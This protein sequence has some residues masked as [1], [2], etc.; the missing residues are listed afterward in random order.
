M[1]RPI[2]TFAYEHPS[3]MPLAL[4]FLVS[5]TALIAL[6]AKHARQRIPKTQENM[7]DTPKTPRH[8]IAA[9]SN[10]TSFSSNKKCSNN[11]SEEVEEQD[12]AMEGFGEG[13]IWQK[14]ILMGEKCQPPVFSGAIYYDRHGNQL[15]ELLRSPRASP[16]PS[17]LAHIEKE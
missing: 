4:A 15:P 3:S 14:S 13:G 2:S 7:P 1:V 12:K 10:K 16:F 5:V 17:F 11:E 8:L 9:P 6:C